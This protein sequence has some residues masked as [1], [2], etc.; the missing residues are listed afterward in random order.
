VQA[1]WPVHL[2]DGDP[3]HWPDDPERW[4]DRP[5]VSRYFVRPDARGSGPAATLLRA[6]K[7]DACA[8]DRRLMPEVIAELP[9]VHWYE[10]APNPEQAASLNVYQRENEQRSKIRRR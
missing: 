1:L 10:R 7:V 4:L 5:G 6:V 2:V 8:T 9:A 3:I